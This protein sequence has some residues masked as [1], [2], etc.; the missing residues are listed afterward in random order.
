MSEPTIIQFFHSDR[1]VT[2]KFAD[3]YKEGHIRIEVKQGSDT[4]GKGTAK[5]GTE[6]YRKAM[7]KAFF[8]ARAYVILAAALQDIEKR[9][10]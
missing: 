5:R 6:T 1:D 10:S 4:S 2:T 7:E 9:R 8:Q 3:F